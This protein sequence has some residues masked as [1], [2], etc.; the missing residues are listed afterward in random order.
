VKV[1]RAVTLMVMMLVSV[2]FLGVMSATAVAQLGG[3]GL[4]ALLIVVIFAALAGIGFSWRRYFP[5]GR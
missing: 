1:H 4:W 3:Q 2:V 5:R